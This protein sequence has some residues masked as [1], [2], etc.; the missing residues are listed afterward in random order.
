MEALQQQLAAPAAPLP[1]SW[2]PPAPGW[3]VLAGA[4]L[5]LMLLVP[6]LLQRRRRRNRRRRRLGRGS[7][8]GRRPE[9]L[10]DSQWLAGINTHLKQILRQRGEEHATRLFG[11]AWLDYL[12][13]RPGSNRDALRPLAADLYKPQI[14]LTPEQ[15]DALLRE[16]RLWVRHEQF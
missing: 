8:F 16:L 12:C 10:S 6:W 5:L 4:L 13:S 11:E 1:I 15:R 7:A 3:W 2:W 14:S 9:G